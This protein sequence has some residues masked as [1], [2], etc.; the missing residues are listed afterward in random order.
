MEELENRNGLFSTPADYLSRP[1][2]KDIVEKITS[3]PA[4]YDVIVGN[5]GIDM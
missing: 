2:A 1:E 5:C 3:S 4:S